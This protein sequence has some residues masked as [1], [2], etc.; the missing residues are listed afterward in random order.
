MTAPF[1]P[2][3]FGPITPLST[4]IYVD[5]ILR[6]SIVTVYEDPTGTSQVGTSKTTEAGSIWVPITKPLTVGTQITARQEYTGTPPDPMI[7]VTGQ[8]VLSN[9]VT[10]LPVPDLGAAFLRKPFSLGTLAREVRET[11]GPQETR[12]N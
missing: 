12:N 11:L 6:N 1:A 10:V 9:P 8:S 3:I 2:V 5:N 4:Q 7:V